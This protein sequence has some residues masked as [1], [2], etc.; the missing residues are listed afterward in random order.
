MMDNSWPDL[1]QRLHASPARIAMVAAGGGSRQISECFR[2]PGASQTFVDAAIP[3]SRESMIQYLGGVSTDSHASAATAR[4]L[5][6]RAF[7]RATEFSAASHTP[8]GLAVTAAL[9]T[10]PP[11]RGHDRIHLVVHSHQFTKQWSLVLPQGDHCRESAETLADDF[12]VAALSDLNQTVDATTTAAQP[13]V[14]Q[15]STFAQF[16][17]VDIHAS[18]A[19]NELQSLASGHAP[20]MGDKQRGS[21]VF[22][23]S[24]NP[25]HRG[26][27]EM[28]AIAATMFATT[29]QP[30]LSIHNVDK[31]I[32]DYITTNERLQLI[33]EIGPPLLTSA[34]RFDQKAALF[35]G[36]RFI[37]GADTAR[38]LDDIRYYDDDTSTRDRS[39]HQIAMHGCRFIVFGRQIGEH[40][41]DAH[42]LVLSPALASLCDLVPETDFR[43]DI[44]S[45]QLRSRTDEST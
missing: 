32:L 43:H 15:Q 11:R 33:R 30:E 19:T 6:V 21:I 28:A 44:S 37:V 22:P 7:Q 9:P 42:G 20:L 23:G 31:P 29:V 35:P 39:I 4:Q 5:A 18:W 45:S 40:F 36:T 27:R 1:L 24:F 2:S 12:I 8:V 38:R 16:G 17:G 10:S 41:C 26:H 3:Y 13:A 34:P 25:V 14:T